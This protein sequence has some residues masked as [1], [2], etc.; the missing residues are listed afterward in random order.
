MATYKGIQGYSVQKL[1]SDP[2]ASEAEGQLWY[3][4]GTGKFRISTAGAGAWATGGAAPVASRQGTGFG[5]QTAALVTGGNKP[6]P[7]TNR[8]VLYNGTSWTVSPGTLNTPRFALAG[9]SNAPQTAGIVFGGTNVDNT[10]TTAN[11][12]SWNG[13]AWSEENDLTTSR[14]QLGGAGDSS[15]AA[16]AM[17][18]GT[19]APAGDYTELWN[20]TSWT[21]VN[22]LNAG[23]ANMGVSGTSTAA[24]CAGGSD[25]PDQ[26]VVETW[27]GTSWTTVNSINTARNRMGGAGSTTA[28]LI[29][30]G[31]TTAS[32][33]V[34][35][36]YD[37]TSWTEVA[38]LGTALSEAGAAGTSSLALYSQ[39]YATTESAITEEWNDPVYSI[40]T[41]TVS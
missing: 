32:V 19:P 33:A 18:S 41:V 10:S 2:T 8:T 1:S 15:T 22:D 17:G 35:E 9:S 6:S 12:E 4:S 5:T 14:K 30:G 21:E 38:D 29:M 23:R 3:N 28:N 39:G 34:T 36:S 13:S 16:L 40:K 37:G 31:Y 7:T 26:S 24:M 20:G 11:S 25:T 27:D